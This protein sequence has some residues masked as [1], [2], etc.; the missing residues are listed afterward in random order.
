MGNVHF[1]H[2]FCSLHYLFHCHKAWRWSWYTGYWPMAIWAALSEQ[3][4]S[5]NFLIERYWLKI[6]SLK[7]PEIFKKILNMTKTL[8]IIPVK[9][10]FWHSQ[11][12][13]QIEISTLFQLVCCY[14][15]HL[16]QLYQTLLILDQAVH[17]WNFSPCLREAVD[18]EILCYF[19]IWSI[20]DWN[21]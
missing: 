9:R 4:E 11:I 13:D 3:N 5:T 15:L 17:H 8:M 16:V 21:L 6:N 10:H 14:L 18:K 1:I 20:F 7:V 19:N 12:K 2:T